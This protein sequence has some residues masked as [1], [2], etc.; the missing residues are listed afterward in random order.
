M[1]DAITKPISRQSTIHLV[2][3]ILRNNKVNISLSFQTYLIT[4]SSPP[5]IVWTFLTVSICI[6]QSNS[7]IV[8]QIHSQIIYKIIVYVAHILLTFS[9]IVHSDDCL[10]MFLFAL[11]LEVWGT[12]LIKNHKLH[13]RCDFLSCRHFV[14]ILSIYIL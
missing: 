3:R 14:D 9:Y 12:N 6:I 8:N 10:W 1:A 11:F 2:F 5:F 4:I 13:H 7:F